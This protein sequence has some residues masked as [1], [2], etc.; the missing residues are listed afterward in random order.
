MPFGR[1][2]SGGNLRTL[3]MLPRNSFDKTPGSKFVPVPKTPFLPP[4]MMTVIAPGVAAKCQ[5]TYE[6]IFNVAT[7]D[8][9]LWKHSSEDFWLFSTPGGRWAIGGKDV[10]EDGFNRSFGWIYQKHTLWAASTRSAWNLVAV[11]W[12]L[13]RA[14]S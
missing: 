14:K 11:E 10:M 3:A 8:Q 6:L 13:L 5:G 1:D 4:V 7:N 2:I 9:P 12:D